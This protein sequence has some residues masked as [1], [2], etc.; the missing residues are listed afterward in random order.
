MK[1]FLTILITALLLSACSAEKELQVQR[2]M[3]QLQSIDTVF[4]VH[5]DKY[6]Y[7][8]FDVKNRVTYFE[9]RDECDVSASLIEALIRH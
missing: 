9:F 1:T 6:L 2:S 4:R 8:W 3:L 5:G 7:K